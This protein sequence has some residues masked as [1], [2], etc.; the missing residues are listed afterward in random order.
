[1][2]F[3]LIGIIIVIWILLDK[4]KKKSGKAPLRGWYKFESKP[5]SILFYVLLI[6]YIAYPFLFPDI[7]LFLSMPYFFAAA[8][9]LF[10]VEQYFYKKEEKVYSF[11]FQDAS[12][13][14]GLGVVTY[15]LFTS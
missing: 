10:G 12:I 14:V 13:W 7:N 1:M 9:A 3:V 6:G 5:L 11:Y 4:R 2:N 8:N 15:L